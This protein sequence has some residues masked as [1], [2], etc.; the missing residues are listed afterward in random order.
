MK[1]Q[2]VKKLSV[3]FFLAAAGV[4]F[5]FIATNGL[6]MN[7][8]VFLTLN[9]SVLI[10][11]LSLG[12]RQGLAAGVLTPVLAYFITSPEFKN[13]IPDNELMC[14]VIVVTE[15]V[16]VGV[17]S[18]VLCVK[19]GKNIYFSSVAALLVGRLLYAAG[20]V[21][22]F[23]VLKDD[24][25]LSNLSDVYKS[26]IG[27]LLNLVVAPPLS[28]VAFK[29]AYGVSG[30]ILENA[31][32]S[33]R[34]K[35]CETIVI[36]GNRTVFKTE[37]KGTEPI[38]SVYETES[39]L[40]NGGIIV[41]RET[42]LALA[43]MLILCKVKSVYSFKITGQAKKLLKANKIYVKCGRLESEITDMKLREEEKLVLSAETPSDAYLILKNAFDEKN[44]EEEK[45]EQ[46]DQ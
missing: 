39:H 41:N 36:N 43:Y 40:L 45:N 33:V 46:P 15:L 27:V 29:S 2:S 35:K 34:T 14:L 18:G 22:A 3:I 26:V 37:E 8:L 21:V 20:I 28:F 44:K 19:K 13:I 32:D 11:G 6:K 16:A 9:I 12:W 42:G 23:I 7:S 31:R 38:V 30:R 17:I 25:I 24:K 5:S 1:K 4:L 10:T